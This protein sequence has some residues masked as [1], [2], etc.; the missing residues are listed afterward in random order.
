M[1]IK[2]WKLNLYKKTISYN[3][4][5]MYPCLLNMKVLNFKDFT[6]KY[7]LQDDT[8]NESQLQ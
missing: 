2:L 8:M 5:C 7:N 4:I 6:K 1:E 3:Y